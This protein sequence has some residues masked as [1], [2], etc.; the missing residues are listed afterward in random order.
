MKF[1]RLLNHLH[2]NI[3]ITI[4]SLRSSELKKSVFISRPV[5]LC[6]YRY[7]CPNVLALCKHNANTVGLVKRHNKLEF[8]KIF[9]NLFANN[10]YQ[11][12][13]NSQVLFIM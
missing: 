9:V 1:C 7:V 3:T 13:E 4:Y 11:I 12:Q 2:I 5:F 6:M 8:G 10:Y